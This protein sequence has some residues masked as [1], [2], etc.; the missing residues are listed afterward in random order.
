MR[1]RQSEQVSE[2]GILTLT[3]SGELTEWSGFDVVDGC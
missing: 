3:A 2:N 1:R